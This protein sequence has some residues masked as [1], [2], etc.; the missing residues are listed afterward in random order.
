MVKEHE[1]LKEVLQA[2]MKRAQDTCK[3]IEEQVRRF[4]NPFEAE[5]QELK[6]KYAQS[7]VGIMKVSEENLQI[8]EKL[9]DVKDKAKKDKDAL[10]EQL[11]LAHHLL[12]EVATRDTIKKLPLA[13]LNRLE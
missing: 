12:T 4:P 9:L 13:E 8:R 6:D 10:E 3:A 7:Q 11:R 2:E 1:A 5:M